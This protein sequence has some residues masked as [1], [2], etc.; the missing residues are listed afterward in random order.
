[1]ADDLHVHGFEIPGNAGYQRQADD[2]AGQQVE[3]R[4]VAGDQHL[5]DDVLEQIDHCG[6]RAGDENHADKGQQDPPALRP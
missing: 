3:H 4:P 6:G 5:V 1:M 2:C